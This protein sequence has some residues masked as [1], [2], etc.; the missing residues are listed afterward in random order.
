MAQ[1]TALLIIDMQMEMAFRSDA[2]RPRVNPNAETHIADLAA[3]F[4]AKDWPVLHV[5]HN[6]P[7]PDSPFRRDAPGG[8]PMPCGAPFGDEPVFYKTGSSGFVG[9]G[10]EAHLHDH[11]IDQLVVVGAVAAF[12]VASTVRSAA[13]LGFDVLVPEDAVIGFALPGRDGSDIDAGVALEVTLATLHADFAHVLPTSHLL[14]T[15]ST[16]LKD[17]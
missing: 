1:I 12:C 16:D 6:A 8:Q 10:L 9:T 13:N 17:R 4:R 3:A 5:H 11:G 2:G 7:Q 14:E 15:L